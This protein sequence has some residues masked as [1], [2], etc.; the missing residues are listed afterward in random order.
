V[1]KLDDTETIWA[2]SKTFLPVRVRRDIKMWPR[3]EQI[4]ENYDQARYT[5]DI[6]KTCGGRRYSQRIVKDGPIH[7]AILLPYQ[8][9]R[10]RQLPSDWTM[11]V[12]LPTREF[13]IKLVRI[14][15]VEVPAGKFKA[16]Y[17]E[18]EPKRFEIWVSSDERHI[19]LKIKGVDGFNY[20]M[21]M[22]SYNK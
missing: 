13:R 19:P 2:D 9:R 8:I 21:V 1:F 3:H 16:Y 7:N 20:M 18:S 12:T 11:K 10:N 15:E 4:E 17:F 5:L 6:T 22:T 14:E